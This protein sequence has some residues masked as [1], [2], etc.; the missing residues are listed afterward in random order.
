MSHDRRPLIGIVG[1]GYDVPKPFGAL[2]V[3]G[4]PQWFATAITAAGGRPVIVPPGA[5]TDLLDVLD[6]LVL[7][8]GG[9]VDPARYGGPPGSAVDVD[10]ARDQDEIELVRA[11]AVAGVPLLGVCRGLQV[12]A[13]AFG[14]SLRSG[15][16]HEHPGD[17]H[18]V[19]TTSGSLA[20]ALLGERPTTSALHHQAVDDPGPAWRATAWTDDGVIEA[21]EPMT[22]EWSA[23]GVQWHP[24]LAWNEWP[25]DPTGPAIFGWLADIAEKRSTRTPVSS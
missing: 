14:G 15:I 1:H 9:D 8:G 7:T 19:T 13:V 17:G 10:P 12:L 24:E 16:G 22:G 2:P 23:L 18:P 3:H 25:T 6:G 5:G 11:A 21:I 4:T 20:R